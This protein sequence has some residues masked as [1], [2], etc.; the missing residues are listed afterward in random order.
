MLIKNRYREE[1]VLM[2]K[3][4]FRLIWLV[5]ML[6]MI[7]GLLL[8]KRDP[9]VMADSR[10][11]AGSDLEI[12]EEMVLTEYHVASDYHQWIYK[13][14][15]KNNSKNYPLDI[16]MNINDLIN[17]DAPGMDAL[18]QAAIRVVNEN[19][20]IA[21]GMMQ[22]LKV[23]GNNLDLGSL[24]ADEISSYYVEI[25]ISS[26]DVHETQTGISCSGEVVFIGTRMP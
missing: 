19:V 21:G 12:A 10:S 6:F 11:G 18:A 8:F 13:V 3:V 26:T 7:I 22:N 9:I 24:D 23:E 1:D 4:N 15:M 2:K 5:C 20:E 14:T 16:T 25:R 17:E